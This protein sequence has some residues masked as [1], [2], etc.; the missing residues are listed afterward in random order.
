MKKFR[1]TNEPNY[2]VF[3]DYCLNHDNPLIEVDKRRKYA[4]VALDMSIYPNEFYLDTETIDSVYQI[5]KTYSVP[6]KKKSKK[7]D[8]YGVVGSIYSHALYVPFENVDQLVNELFDVV[9]QHIN[10][11]K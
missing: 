5:M 9:K 6:P 7:D 4:V 2:G 10:Q 8:S 3:I 11:V 1:L